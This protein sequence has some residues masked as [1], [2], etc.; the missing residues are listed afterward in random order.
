M[1]RMHLDETKNENAATPKR[2][3]P[4]LFLW[5]GIA[6]LAALPRLLL[7]ERGKFARGGAQPDTMH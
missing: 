2:W 7:M 4:R 5:L 1:T 3:L 6:L